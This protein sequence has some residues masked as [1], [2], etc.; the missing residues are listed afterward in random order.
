MLAAVVAQYG[1]LTMPLAILWA[2]CLAVAIWRQ[3]AGEPRITTAR[4]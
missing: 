3:P 2:L 4:S 1:A